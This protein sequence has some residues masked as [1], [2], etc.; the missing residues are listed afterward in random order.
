MYRLFLRIH[1]TLLCS[2]YSTS[3]TI[4]TIISSTIVKTINGVPDA[5][6]VLGGDRRYRASTEPENPEYHR[7]I[8]PKPSSEIPRNYS[9]IID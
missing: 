5:S 2:L 8:G 7:K 1:R 6:V 9:R 4:A 3:S